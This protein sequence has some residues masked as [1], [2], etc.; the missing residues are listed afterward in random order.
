MRS[1]YGHPRRAGDE[2]TALLQ[3]S[4]PSRLYFTYNDLCQRALGSLQL[5]SQEEP[6]EP[7]REGVRLNGYIYLPVH[8]F[9]DIL[10]FLD[11]RS[12]GAIACTSKRLRSVILRSQSRD[13]LSGL[14]MYRID[15]SSLMNRLRGIRSTERE[16]YEAGRFIAP[17]DDLE[18]NG[19]ESDGDISIGSYQEPTTIVTRLLSS[20]PFVIFATLICALAIASFSSVISI[21]VSVNH[22]LILSG[23]ICLIIVLYMLVV[24]ERIRNQNPFLIRD[25]NN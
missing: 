9:V 16:N 23:G 6:S 10:S 24:W 17:A 4:V 14:P 2:T 18:R 13:A 3:S 22:V 8:C 1:S 5:I 15:P 12:N 25:Y 20:C 11:H 19:T 21:Y 7:S